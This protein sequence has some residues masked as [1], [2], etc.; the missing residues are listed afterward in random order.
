M[1]VDRFEFTKNQKREMA[2]RSNGICEAGKFGTFKFYGMA[3]ADICHRQA[4]EFDHIIADGLKRQ[5]IE[6][7]DEGL[8]VCGVHHKIKTH[9]HDRPKIQKAKN[10]REKL[11]GITNPK[12]PIP[13]SKASGLRKRMNGTVERRA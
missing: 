2:A 10:I 8:H 5:K 11:A 4:Q 6:S 3:D 7:I 13:G 12:R 1:T 9:S